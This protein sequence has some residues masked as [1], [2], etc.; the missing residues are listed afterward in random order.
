MTMRR[1]YRSATGGAWNTLPQLLF[2][3]NDISCT[4]RLGVRIPTGKTHHY[5]RRYRAS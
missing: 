1:L 5:D 2:V 4:H 3:G